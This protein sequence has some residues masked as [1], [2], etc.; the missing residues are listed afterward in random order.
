M[1]VFK[2]GRS[3][4][5]RP[6]IAAHANNENNDVTEIKDTNDATIVAC[7]QKVDPSDYN[8]GYVECTYCYTMAFVW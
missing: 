5:P 3:V 6:V 7:A 8:H 2:N 1:W 4:G